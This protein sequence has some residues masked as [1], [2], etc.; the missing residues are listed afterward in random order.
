MTTDELDKL[1]MALPT[2]Y[3]DTL[4]ERTQ[5]SR[6]MVSQVMNGERRNFEIIDAAIELAKEEKAKS[7]QRKL[8]I[9]IL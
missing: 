3:I 4:C 7:E 2:K 5:F 9:N 8:E 6:S 1:R